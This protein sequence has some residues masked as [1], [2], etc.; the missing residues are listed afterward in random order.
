MIRISSQSVRGLVWITFIVNVFVLVY[1]VWTPA[2]SIDCGTSPLSLEEVFCLDPWLNL[3]GNFLLLTPTALL[4]MLLF[5]IWPTSRILLIIFSTTAA[6]ETVQ[7]FVP[8]RDPSLMDFL[9]NVIGASAM[10]ILLGRSRISSKK[11]Q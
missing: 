9:L 11:G 6:I 7:N 8:G 5:P 1:L 2:T 3:L 4:L 10:A